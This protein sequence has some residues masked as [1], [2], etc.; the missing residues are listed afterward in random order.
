[1][2]R[3]P[4]PARRRLQLAAAVAHECDLN[5]ISVKGPE[6]LNKYIGASEQ[7]VRDLFARAAAAAP[8]VL[9]FDEVRPRAVALHQGPPQTG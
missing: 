5:F 4:A 2:F 9:F 1:M 3:P 8:S 7:A 6:L